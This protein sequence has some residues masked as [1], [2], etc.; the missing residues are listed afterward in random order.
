MSGPSVNASCLGPS[1]SYH[2][3][4]LQSLA[5]GGYSMR[6]PDEIANQGK[7]TKGHWSVDQRLERRFLECACAT[8]KQRCEEAVPGNCGRRAIRRDHCPLAKAKPYK[9][10]GLRAR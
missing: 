4:P 5:D 1:R 10:A 7:R 6:R 3:R 8:S 2:D 9:E